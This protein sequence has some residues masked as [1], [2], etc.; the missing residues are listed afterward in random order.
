MSWTHL[1][2][3]N[4]KGSPIFAQ[5]VDPKE[6]GELDD[7]I[8][9]N[10]A[11]GNPVKRNIKLTGEIITVDKKDLLPPVADVPIVVQTGLNYNDHVQEA[12]EVGYKVRCSSCLG[13]E[14][15]V[16]ALTIFHLPAHISS[17]GH[18]HV[19]LLHTRKST[20]IR[21]SKTRSTMKGN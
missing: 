10:V 8:K 12:T 1:V 14:D 13:I 5:L 9:V 4:H 18:Q 15:F 17:G 7:K 19:S 20:C 16:D 2:R 21:S 6:S 3:F 11:T